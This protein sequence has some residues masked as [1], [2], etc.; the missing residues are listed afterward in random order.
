MRPY[1]G[2]FAVVVALLAPACYAAETEQ[3]APTPIDDIGFSRG[4]SIEDC[5]SMWEPKTHMTKT[6]WRATC[7]RIRAERLPPLKAKPVE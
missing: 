7:D 3:A 5:M 6:Q 2:L 1:R 4:Q